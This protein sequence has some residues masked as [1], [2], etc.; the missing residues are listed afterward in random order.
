[1]KYFLLIGIIFLSQVALFAAD[2]GPQQIVTSNATDGMDAF[3][4][5]MDGDGLMDAVDSEPTVNNWE[6]VAS[7]DIDL[8]EFSSNVRNTYLE[9]ANNPSSSTFMKIGILN[10][11]EYED[12]NGNYKFTS[13]SH[14]SPNEKY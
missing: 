1:M 11:S 5:D 14:Y 3:P 4:A 8:G 10:K 7:Q 2:F 12:Q 6:L 9:N 13:R